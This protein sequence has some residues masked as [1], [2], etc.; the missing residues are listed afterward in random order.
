[1]KEEKIECEVC[2]KEAKY[3]IQDLEN[4]DEFYACEKHKHNF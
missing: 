2:D 4:Q 1:M 3:R